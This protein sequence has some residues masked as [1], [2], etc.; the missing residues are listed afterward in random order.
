ML[1]GNQHLMNGF[2]DEFYK[3]LGYTAGR[4]GCTHESRRPLSGEPR[5]KASTSAAAHR[6]SN[7]QILPPVTIFGG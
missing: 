7:P 3:R 4:L 1:V 2:D 6:R 5:G